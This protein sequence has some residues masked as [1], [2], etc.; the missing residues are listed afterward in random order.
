MSAFTGSKKT[1]KHQ[2]NDSALDCLLYSNAHK[3]TH[4][5]AVWRKW[6]VKSSAS[7]SCFVMDHGRFAVFGESTLGKQSWPYKNSKSSKCSL[8]MYPRVRRRP[9]GQQ[10]WK[11]LRALKWTFE[12]D[13]D[14]ISE[15]FPHLC[16]SF[17]SRR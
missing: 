8:D 3:Q 4:R 15:Q 7:R 9:I 14:S 1:N 13:K 16:K 2:N 6:H 10:R 5:R 17:L 12:Q 11:F